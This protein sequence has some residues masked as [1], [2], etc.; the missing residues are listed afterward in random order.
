MDSLIYKI[1]PH[2]RKDHTML[3]VAD[4]TPK[5]HYKKKE[6]V[7]ICESKGCHNIAIRGH[8]VIAKGFG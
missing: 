1:S 5:M 3:V 2:P 8:S 7:T 6:R 4:V